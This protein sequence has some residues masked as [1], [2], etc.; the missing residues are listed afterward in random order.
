MTHIETQSTRALPTPDV[1]PVKLGRPMSDTTDADAD[2]SCAQSDLRSL[3][4]SFLRWIGEYRRYSPLT[5]SA[6]ERDCRRF[7]EFLQ[8]HGASTAADEVTRGDIYRFIISLDHL[9]PAT[10]RRALYALSSFFSYLVEMQSIDHNPAAGIVP[11]KLKRVLPRAPSTQKCQQILEACKTATEQCVIG[12]MLLAGLRR[13]EV[14]GLRMGDVA[15]DLGQL[16]VRGKAGR[17]RIVPV[18]SVLRGVL[19]HYLEQREADSRWVIVNAV[20]RQMG[21]STF[22]RV[23]RRVLKR[24]GLADSGITPHSLRHAFATFLVRAGVDVATIS[25]LL[26]HSNI[27]TTSIY[28]HA[29]DSTKK[30]AVELLDFAPATEVAATTEKHAY[31]SDPS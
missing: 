3:L 23:C 19:R 21:I 17:E 1:E 31:D 16:L 5:V 13:S 12:L 29:T 4:D 6:Y 20:G 10:V 22:Y 27:A 8:K 25:E 30:E 2:A 26:G 11:P 28:L 9:S 14:L 24:A 15:V 7:I 18:G